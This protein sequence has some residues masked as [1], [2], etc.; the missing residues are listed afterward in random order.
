MHICTFPNEDILQLPMNI[1]FNRQWI[2]TS[3]ANEV[4]IHLSSYVGC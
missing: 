1:Y 3:S 2:Y 4:Y